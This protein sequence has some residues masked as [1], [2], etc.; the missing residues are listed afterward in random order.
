MYIDI[1]TIE[2]FINDSKHIPTIKKEESKEL[3]T[4]YNTFWY[5]G[6]IITVGL[7]IIFI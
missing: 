2:D 7:L 1:Y 5:V 3:L 4:Y 6:S